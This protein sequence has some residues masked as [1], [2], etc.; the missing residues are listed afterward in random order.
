MANIGK[1]LRRHKVV[2]LRHPISPNTKPL[3]E[4]LPIR[5]L[6][7]PQQQPNY[8]PSKVPELEPAK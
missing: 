3:P 8:L 5:N 1:P 4:D 7:A 6:P 2:P